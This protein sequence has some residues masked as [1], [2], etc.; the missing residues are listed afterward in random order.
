[1]ITKT[2]IVATLGPA[3]AA[4]QTIS[5]L[6]EAGVRVFRL[7]FSHGEL[8]A[9]QAMLAAVRNAAQKVPFAVSVMGDLCGPK[10]RLCPIQPDGGT[11]EPGQTVR[12]LRQLDAGRPDCFATT[13][14]ELVDR[15]R[16][17][18]RVLLDDGAIVLQAESKTD[19]ALLCRV[20]V[21]GPVR[22]RKGVNLP[23]TDLG[24]PAITPRD[25][26]WADWAVQNQL[27]Y[28]ALSFVQQ[29]DEI[30]QLKQAL[31]QKHSPIKVV[32]KIEKPRAVD[33]LE[34]IVRTADAI[35]V[36]RGDLG[37]EMPAAEAPL[38]QKRI[39]LLGRR[40]GKPVIVATQVLQSMIENP[41]PTRAEVSD[42][43]NAVMDYADAIMLSGET[44]VGKYPVESAQV[45][46]QVCARTEEYLD[47]QKLPRPP[48]ETDPDLH[49]L[50]VIARCVAQMLDEIPCALVLVAAK[51]GTTARLLSKAR[52]DVPIISFCP[53]ERINQQM[54]LHYGV[55]GVVCPMMA[56]LE[57]F[58]AYAQKAVLKHGWAKP[59]QQVLLLPGRDLLAGRD[60]QAIVLHSLQQPTDAPVS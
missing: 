12:I 43:A 44:A 29:A 3:S 48:I 45:I 60:S 22:S 57:E 17:G 56:S 10:I 41:S 46:S 6:I 25:W 23:D 15:V 38:I 36:A 13:L 49:S 26:Q 11:I 59:G 47:A 21:G 16:L 9:H 24:I 58:T 18:Q 14:P 52:I 5:R 28:L 37:V 30:V 33:N 27:D 2:R 20:L 31:Q 55:S 42:I 54:G 53:D 4:P 51:T 35:L 8:S 1:M 34:A 50:S 40:F 39:T 32:A 7:N 19:D